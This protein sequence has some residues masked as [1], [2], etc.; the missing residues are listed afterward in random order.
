MMEV[1]ENKGR[2]S[3]TESPELVHEETSRDEKE[4]PYAALPLADR[5][6]TDA[7]HEGR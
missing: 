3:A 4:P 1:V 6:K 2:T 7:E 5:G